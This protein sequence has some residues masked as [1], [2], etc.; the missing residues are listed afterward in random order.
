MKSNATSPSSVNATTLAFILVILYCVASVLRADTPATWKASTS[1]TMTSARNSPADWWALL[2]DTQLQQLIGKLDLS[3][4]QLAAAVQRVEQARAG[5][6][7]ARSELFPLVSASVGGGRSQTSFAT[8]AFLPV[9]RANQWDAAITASYEVDLWGRIRSNVRSARASVLADERSVEALR[10]SLCAELTDAYLTMRGLEAE[11]GIVEQALLTRRKNLELTLQRKDAGAVSD[12]EVE[13]ARTD[14][15]AAEVEAAA[16]KQGRMEL[17]NAIALVVGSN[18]SEF[19]LA[20]TGR[21]PAAPA[22]PNVLPCELLRRRPDVAAA[23]WRIEAATGQ[24]NAARTAWYPTLR[25]QARAGVSAEHAGRFDDDAAR[26][27]SIGFS[28]SLPLFDGG[29]RK[30]ALEAAKAAQ[31]E[32]M[33]QQRQII[34]TAA[35]DA[36][37]ALGKVFW[38]RQQHERASA[39]A[40]AAERSA[41]LVSEKYAAGGVDTFQLLLAERLRLDAARMR[42][43]AQI[44]SLRAV[45]TLIRALGGGWSR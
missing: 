6:N 33:E 5:V 43:R 18:A 25:L 8:A 38:G 4:P 34:L 41:S 15:L 16:L 7:Q 36:E 42:V 17:E 12:L 40:S 9:R 10:L 2:N 13:Q 32:G 3:T 20:W 24:V 28:F 29:R 1:G 44:T 45:V 14:L 23:S 35:A 22:V 19:R 27:G 21:L 39:A 31:R 26:A 37:T 11:L 30:A